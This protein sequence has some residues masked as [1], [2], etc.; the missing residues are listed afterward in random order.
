M[1]TTGPVRSHVDFYTDVQ[2]IESFIKNYDTFTVIYPIPTNDM[3]LNLPTDLDKLH[4]YYI[5]T[6]QSDL[7]V[8]INSLS[9]EIPY[10]Y[11]D[12]SKISSDYDSNTLELTKSKTVILPSGYYSFEMLDGDTLNIKDYFLPPEDNYILKLDSLEKTPLEERLDITFENNTEIKEI[13]RFRAF[14]NLTY[15]YKVEYDNVTKLYKAIGF[16]NLTFNKP[17]IGGSLEVYSEN[18]ILIK[19]INIPNGT[20]S[21]YD[22]DYY[23]LFNGIKNIVVSGFVKTEDGQIIHV[24]E[25]IP[26]FELKGLPKWFV[27]LMLLIVWA[28]V[29]GIL[30]KISDNILYP[31]ITTILFVAVG[32]TVTLYTNPLVMALA[33]LTLMLGVFVIFMLLLL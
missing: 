9:G 1:I 3:L 30:I 18:G 22:E 5:Q 13:K 27:A 23:I 10:Y 11:I 25:V 2:P 4:I 20:K 8:S 26:M 16:L 32:L 15:K 12:Y 14:Y 31:V 6:K 28:L 17:L 29:V 24:Y 21:I 7:K 33:I 19:T